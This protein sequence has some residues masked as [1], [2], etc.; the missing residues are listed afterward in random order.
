M[1]IK[2]QPQQKYFIL[3]GNIGAGKSTFLKI[4]KN[5]LHIQVVLEPHEKWQKIDGKHN[6][7]EKFYHETERWAYTFQTYAFVTRVVAQEEYAKQNPYQIQLLERSVFSDRYCFAHAAHENGYMNM[8]EWK[9]YQE[10]F[11]WL[12]DGYV[13]KPNGFIYLRANP[14]TCYKRLVNRKRQEEFGISLDYLK[15]LDDK[16]EKWLIQ[17]EGVADYL[18]DVPVLSLECNAD[19]EHNKQE[20]EKHIEALVAF[21]STLPDVG[22]QESQSTLFVE[23]NNQMR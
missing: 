20:Q 17:K 21:F 15:Q 14:E 18:K 4:I 11:S 16:H 2:K 1:S 13:Q 12:V 19:F 10:W 9:L 3:E 8:L 7:L 23:K 22:Y 6:L 5:Y